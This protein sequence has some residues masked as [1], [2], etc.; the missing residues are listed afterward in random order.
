MK[1]LRIPAALLSA[2]RNDLTRVHVHAYERVGFLTAGCSVL[3][4]GGLLLLARGYRP[5]DDADYVLNRQV[6]AMIGP[7]A[8]RKGLQEAYR[9]CSALIHV[10]MHEGAGVPR[11][12]RLDLTE[13]Q[14]FVP[15]FFNAVPRMPHGLV[16]LSKDSACGLLWS[17]PTRTP[18]YL[19]RISVVGVSGATGRESA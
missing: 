19:D 17:S 13:G 7:D 18:Q 11:F 5:V 12:S 1:Q 9:S 2:I 16:V 10:H 8:M 4:G 6:G 15:S 3:E 14:K